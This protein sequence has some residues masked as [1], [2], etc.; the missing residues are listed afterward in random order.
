[1]Y[2][3]PSSLDVDKKVGYIVVK[4]MT[5]DGAVVLEE[6]ELVDLVT[7]DGGP[8]ARQGHGQGKPVR[9][10]MFKILSRAMESEV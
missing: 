9:S 3:K 1:M 8:I 7:I 6:R 5:G 2:K 10:K 4:V